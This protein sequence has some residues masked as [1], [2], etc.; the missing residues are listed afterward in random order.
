MRSVNFELIESPQL[1]QSLTKA[2]FPY[3]NKH[4]PQHVISGSVGSMIECHLSVDLF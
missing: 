3:T 4:T 2:N 1:F